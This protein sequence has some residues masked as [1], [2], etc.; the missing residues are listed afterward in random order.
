M[1]GALLVWALIKLGKVNLHLLKAQLESM[2]RVAFLKLVLLNAILVYLSTEKW[3]SVDQALRHSSDSV[4]SR[5]AAYTASS[6][7]MALGLVLPVQIGMATARTL[8]THAYGRPLKRGTGGTLME[9]GFDLLTVLPM[10]VASAATWFWRGDGLLW[11]IVAVAMIAITLLACGP[12]VKLL[13][14]LAT[15][16]GANAS[17]NRI[18]CELGELRHSE[19][20]QAGLV[21]RLVV[22]SAIRF[23]IVVLMAVQTARIVNLTIPLWQMAAAVP[24]VFLSTILAVTPGGIGVNELTSTTALKLFGTPLAVAAQWSVANRLLVTLS[25]FTVAILALFARTLENSG[26]SQAGSKSKPVPQE[27]D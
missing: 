3:R 22:L 19:L 16:C 27:A 9:Q 26:V 24:F 21:R 8:G 18:L 5:I 25:C 23:A 17:R 14:R 13:R 7:G 4:P 12:L 15:S 2:S 6:S 10:A 11:L 1:L 20:L